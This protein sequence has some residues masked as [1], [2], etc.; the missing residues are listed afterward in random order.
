MRRSALVLG[1]L[2]TLACRPERSGLAAGEPLPARRSRLAVAETLRGGETEGFALALAPRAFRFPADH[3]PHPEFRTEWWYYTGNLATREGRRFGFQLTFF[4]QALVAHPPERRSPWAASQVYLAHF[5]LTDVQARSFRSFER[6]ERG[7]QGLAGAVASPF[8]VWVGDWASRG[9]GPDAPPFHLIARAPLEEPAEPGQEVAVDLELSPGK[10]IVAQGDRGL[11]RKGDLPGQAT[12]YYSLPRLPAAGTVRDG[13]ASYPVSGLAWMDREWGTSS[14][15]S[16][17]VGWDWFSLQLDDGR[18]LMLYRLR[19]RDGGTAPASAGTLIAQDGASRPLRIAP[20]TIEP[21]GSWTS[22]RSA[23]RYPAAFHLRLPAEGLDLTVRP[24][25]ADQELD[26]S[27]LYWEGA[28]EVTGS[29]GGRG[30]VELTGYSHGD[31]REA[32]R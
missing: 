23:A 15:G 11:S 9:Q 3:G 1:L 8:R 21:L 14:L 19:Q 4:R 28:V 30:Y 18:D 6:L 16:D 32:E 10:P 22:P 2:L 17:Q 27:F 12:Y 25:L 29:V 24:L 20:G 26:T 13:R 31:T 5:T 7:A